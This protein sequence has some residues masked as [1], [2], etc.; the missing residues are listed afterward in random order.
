[1]TS[2]SVV[3][4]SN[5]ANLASERFGMDIEMGLGD[6]GVVSAPV[7]SVIN[8]VCSNVFVAGLNTV[9][10][11]LAFAGMSGKGTIPA[12]DDD[13]PSTSPKPNRAAVARL[14]VGSFQSNWGAE[15]T[16]LKTIDGYKI[17]CLAT[18]RVDKS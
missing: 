16:S 13:T 1:M 7:G 3:P 12:H 6:S 14:P 4:D 2:L 8:T 17:L 9:S 11:S 18:Q 10:P 5:K 15:A